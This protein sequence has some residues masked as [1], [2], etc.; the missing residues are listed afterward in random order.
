MKNLV[1]VSVLVVCY[2]HEKYIRQCIESILNQK[3]NFR[4]EIIIHDDASNDDSASIIR[5]YVDKYPDIVK[6]FFEEKPIFLKE[7]INIAYN[8]LY[9]N[10]KGKYFATCE[11]DDYW[12]DMQKLQIQYD[13]MEK[14]NNCAVCVHPVQ[15]VDCNRNEESCGVVP[16]QSKEY[17]M[18][19]LK[20]DEIFYKWIR[21]GTFFGANSFFIRRSCI[22]E[23][24]IP[25][26]I[27]IS[28]GIEFANFL[29]YASLGD[30]LF[31][32]QIMAVKR[33][34]NMGSL[35]FER[36]QN[37]VEKILADLSKIDNILESFDEF[38]HGKYH[39]EIENVILYHKLRSVRLKNKMFESIDFYSGNEISK[40]N[41]Y[42][43]A[44]RNKIMDLTQKNSFLFLLELKYT[45]RCLRKK[46]KY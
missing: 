14:K 6:C 10:A 7:P 43:Y 40:C 4:Y 1:E 5:E 45:N 15:L 35:S 38:S 42:F 2:N 28:G 34:N 13:Y 46:L 27:T 12:S 18:Q 3:T 17:Y 8:I 41:N 21:E 33:V 22:L 30:I 25:D 39:L 29:E 26:F 9:K 37:N 23:D 44:I 24:Q 31:L 16:Y 32:P 20:L 36:Q 19:T 11:G